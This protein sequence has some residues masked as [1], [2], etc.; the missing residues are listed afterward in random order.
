MKKNLFYALA[1]IAI[2]G[3]FF[4]CEKPPVEPKPET[5]ID[6]VPTTGATGEVFF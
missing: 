2:V 6:T 4:S 3:V 1:F 5:P